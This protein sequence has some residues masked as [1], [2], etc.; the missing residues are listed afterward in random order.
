MEWTDNNMNTVPYSIL[1]TITDGIRWCNRKHKPKIS[2]LQTDTVVKPASLC[3]LVQKI[4]ARTKEFYLIQVYI[5]LS[6]P[7]IFT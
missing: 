3:F 7:Y 1:K 5:H 6:R 4:E 2:T